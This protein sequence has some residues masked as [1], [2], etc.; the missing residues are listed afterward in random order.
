MAHITNALTQTS[1]TTYLLDYSATDPTLNIKSF[2]RFSTTDHYVIGNIP[3]STYLI[4]YIGSYN[5]AFTCSGSNLP[6]Q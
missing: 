6:S 5:S 1:P 3:G 4:G 2:Y